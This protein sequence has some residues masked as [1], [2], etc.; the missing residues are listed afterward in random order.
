[1]LP[2]GLVGTNVSFLSVIIGD[3]TAVPPN[4]TTARLGNLTG[5]GF[6]NKRQLNI[7]TTYILELIYPG[8]TF[9]IC[10]TCRLNYIVASKRGLPL[11]SQC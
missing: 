9:P 11:C 7:S 8:E 4:G 1:M 3:L 6:W 2:S 5:G 10:G